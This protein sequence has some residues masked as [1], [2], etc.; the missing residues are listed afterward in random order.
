VAIQVIEHVDCLKSLP[1]L[2]KPG[3]LTTL[4]SPYPRWNWGTRILEHLQLIRMRS[5]EHKNLTDFSSFFREISPMGKVSV[6]AGETQCAHSERS[7]R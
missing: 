7:Q 4:S 5:S 3:G 2:C 6:R 1:L